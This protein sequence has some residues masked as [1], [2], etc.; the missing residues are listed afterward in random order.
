MCSGKRR[1][2]LATAS[3]LFRLLADQLVLR[4][5]QGCATRVAR[6]RV[7]RRFPAAGTSADR[8]S[9][10][11]SLRPTL[12][13]LR[14]L[15]RRGLHRSPCPLLLRPRLF[16]LYTTSSSCQVFLS[17]FRPLPSNFT[18]NRL[19]ELPAPSNDPSSASHTPVLL[20]LPA[21]PRLTGKFW[22][23][24][25]VK[26]TECPRISQSALYLCGKIMASPGKNPV[27]LFQDPSGGR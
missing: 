11:Q 16:Q 27:F 24:I 12:P 9:A 1:P 23:E 17:H 19:S 26:T 13:A 4:P 14:L 10:Q 22:Q 21:L 15:C 18:T 5:P 6:G 2:L 8:R 20:P 25:L 7:L 3:V